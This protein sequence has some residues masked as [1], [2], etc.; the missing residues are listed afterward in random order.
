MP[1]YT[2]FSVKNAKSS[3]HSRHKT[4]VVEE[5]PSNTPRTKGCPVTR[6]IGYVPG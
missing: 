2:Y 3:Y 4:F 1:S 6:A 5:D